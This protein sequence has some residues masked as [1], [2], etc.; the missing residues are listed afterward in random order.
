MER[1][2]NGIT[3]MNAVMVILLALVIVFAGVAAYGW[4]RPQGTTTVTVELTLVDQAKNESTLTIYAGMD[5][6]DFENKIK[7]EF[8]KL[9]P[10]ATINYVGLGSGE[11][12]S[13]FVS[14]YQAGHVACGVYVGSTG[15]VETA[16]K[17]GAIETY[18]NPMVD[19][20]AYPNGSYDPSGTWTPIYTLP[21]VLLYNTNLVSSSDVPTSYN[22]L[23]DPKWNGKLVFDSPAILNAAGPLF[24]HLYT[25]LGNASWTTLMNGIKNNNPIILESSSD[26]YQKVALGEASIGIGL[27]NDYLAGKGTQ[28]VGVAW[29]DPVTSVALVGVLA[30]NAP[31]PAMA[32]LFLQ[33]WTAAAG[34][35][36]IAATGRVPFNGPVAAY[37]ILSG[38]L[39]A[40]TDV[41]P[42]GSNNPDY[43]AN[44]EAWSATFTDIFG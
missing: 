20:M 22:D 31:H 44:P 3:T 28:P 26:V 38:V 42:G 5:T 18:L 1:R 27:V 23:A 21:V 32:K 4:M 43:V 2:K 37:T 9:Y 19:L 6:P 41:V 24:A 33:W 12:L 36:T 25:I 7:P 16:R 13:R 34:Q 39:P 17:S 29:I 40:G 35:F 14:E 8:L 10:W 11:A 30:K 15:A